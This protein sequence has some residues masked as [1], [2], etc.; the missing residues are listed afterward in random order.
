MDYLDLDSRMKLWKMS[1]FVFFT[2]LTICVVQ[3]FPTQE[4]GPSRCHKMIG[5][6]KKLT[7]LIWIHKFILLT[8]LYLLLFFF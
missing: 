7:D 5:N 8:F 4:L 3:W 2:P 6:E 1:N